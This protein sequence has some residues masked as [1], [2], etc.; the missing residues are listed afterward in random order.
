MS[1]DRFADSQLVSA[2]KGDSK[3]LQTTDGHVVLNLVPLLNEA[4]KGVQAEAS[5]LFGKNVTLPAITSSK[6]PAADCRSR[7]PAGRSRCS[8]PRH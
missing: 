6:I 2:L 7:R 3:A 4:L 1:A 8:R 5:A